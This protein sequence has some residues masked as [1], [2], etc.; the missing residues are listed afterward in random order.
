MS[1]FLAEAGRAALRAEQAEEQPPFELVTYGSEGSQAGV[2]LD[3][4]SALLAAED[5]ARYGK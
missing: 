5:E 1:A 3:Q 2:N 4:P